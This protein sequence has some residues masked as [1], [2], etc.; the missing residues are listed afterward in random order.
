MEAPPERRAPPT[1]AETAVAKADAYVRQPGVA[2][3]MPYVLGA[4]A[5]AACLWALRRLTRVRLT[6]NR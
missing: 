3:F 2:E 5:L 6:L 1:A 4:L